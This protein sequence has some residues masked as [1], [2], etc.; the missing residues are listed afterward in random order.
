MTNKKRTSKLK[1]DKNDKLSWMQCG[2]IKH[3]IENKHETDDKLP[4]QEQ[5]P[6][7]QR[8]KKST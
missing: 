6:N 5:L 1:F 7:N 3:F 2:K 8:T 4:E